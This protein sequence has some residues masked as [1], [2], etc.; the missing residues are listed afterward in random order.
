VRRSDQPRQRSPLIGDQ[1]VNVR[2]LGHHDIKPL[3]GPQTGITRQAVVAWP[4][5]QNRSRHCPADRIN[6]R[7]TIF[8]AMTSALILNGQ[9]ANLM[10]LDRL[11]SRLGATADAPTIVSLAAPSAA[12][13]APGGESNLAAVGEIAAALPGRWRNTAGGS[14]A[15]P[16]SRH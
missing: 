13:L 14:G 11:G 2:R 15:W 7:S 10:V 4:Q 3:S 1:P 12:R 9:Q 6:A 8:S 16:A 5:Y